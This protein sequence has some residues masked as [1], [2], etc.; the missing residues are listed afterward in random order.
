VFEL[1]PALSHQLP[2][3]LGDLGRGLASM[4]DFL[5]EEVASRALADKVYGDFVVLA[6]AH[7]FEVIASLIHVF[8]LDFGVGAACLCEAAHLNTF[9]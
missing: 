3:L 1:C 4:V 9:F 8:V 5:E 6:R 7:F 2:E